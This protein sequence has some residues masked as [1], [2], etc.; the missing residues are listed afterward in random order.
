MKEESGQWFVVR[1]EREII[2]KKI[3]KIDILMKGQSL[4]TKLV[5]ASYSIK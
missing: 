3:R 2:L 1:E 4:I 5:V